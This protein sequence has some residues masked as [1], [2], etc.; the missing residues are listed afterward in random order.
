MNDEQG[1][2]QRR[3]VGFSPEA[4]I[5]AEVVGAGIGDVSGR[6]QEF[7]VHVKGVREGV[8]PAE[9]AF[10]TTEAGVCGLMSQLMFM[11]MRT[12]VTRAQIKHK[13]AIAMELIEDEWGL[14]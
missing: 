8:G 6:G 1:P 13:M 11:M 3:V 2:A 12:G 10:S 4:L 14:R 9:T 7:V 5:R